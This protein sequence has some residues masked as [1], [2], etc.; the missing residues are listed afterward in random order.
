[1]AADTTK[2][3]TSFFFPSSFPPSVLILPNEGKIK[4]H[5]FS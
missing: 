4:L 1:M 5:I 2:V 3:D